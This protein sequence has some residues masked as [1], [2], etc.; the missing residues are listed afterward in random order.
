MHNYPLD[1]A[2]IHDC[3]CIIGA[4]GRVGQLAGGGVHL[5]LSQRYNYIII[6][7]IKIIKIMVLEDGSDD[8]LV[9]G[10]ISVSLRDIII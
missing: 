4:G 9:A 2:N 7:I 8:W 6:I 5:C 1:N 10:Y 3:D